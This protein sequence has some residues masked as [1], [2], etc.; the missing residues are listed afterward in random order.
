MFTCLCWYEHWIGIKT[1]IESR[2]RC[3][4]F[5]LNS[6]FC[7]NS[8][9]YCSMHHTLLIKRF[10]EFRSSLKYHP[11]QA[12][13]YIYIGPLQATMYIYI[14]PL[15]ATMYIYIGPLMEYLLTTNSDFLIPMS[16][17]PNVVECRRYFKLLDQIILV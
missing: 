17:Q 12:T 2:L 6:C 16:L 14:G 9:I 1:E 8:Y 15:Q 7:T 5:F 13:M 10:N 11:L 3:I 4:V